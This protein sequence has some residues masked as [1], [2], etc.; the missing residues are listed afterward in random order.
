MQGYQLADYQEVDFSVAM[1]GELDRALGQH[2]DKGPR[3]EDL[4][5]AYWKPSRGAQRY[6]AILRR[7]NLPRNGERHLQGNVAFTSEYLTR[8]LAERPEACGIA[9]LHSHLGP[10]WQDMSDDDIVA[11]RDRLGGLVASASGFP[12]L[13]LTRGTDGAWSAR[14]WLRSGRHRYDRRWASTVRSVGRHL[15]ISYHPKLRPPSPPSP[16]Q[17]AT[18]SVWGKAAQADLARA[19]IGIVGLGSVG[20]IV[21]ETLSRTGLDQ[22]I[23]IDPDHIEERNLDRTLGAYRSDVEGKLLKVEIAKR[24]INASHTSTRFSATDIAEGIQDT[25]GLANALDCDA[26]MCCVDRPWPRHILNVLAYSH[27]IP[28]VDGGILARVREDG[29]LLH[30]DWRI[31]TVGPEHGCLYCLDALRRSDVALDRDGLLDDPD[32]LKGL[33]QADRERYG[34]RNVFAF[35][36]S[37]ASHQ[38]LQLAGLISGNER[39]AG[40]GPQTYHAYPGTMEVGNT[41]PC[42]A[43]CD[44]Q[45]LTALAHENIL[46]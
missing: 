14:F 7:L 35:S 3:Q 1:T 27:L 41:T 30:V 43:D 40:R 18:I 45:P 26:I 17:V 9:L 36:L 8:V 33:S 22:L 39:I 4:T 2:L 19:R 23:L 28:I 13:G 15:R 42:R 37:V 29:R 6:T 44:I 31:H 24:V 21:A 16:S 32:Y 5:F 25:K 34:R 46:E 20:S 11:E 38:V 10:G 12:V